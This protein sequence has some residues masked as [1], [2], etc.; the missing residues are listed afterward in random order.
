[1]YRRKLAACGTTGLAVIFMN[2]HFFLPGSC[3]AWQ[4]LCWEIC[5]RGEPPLHHQ[6]S[7]ER[8]KDLVGEAEYW[9][10]VAL[11]NAT[12]ALVPA[13]IWPAV[14]RQELQI[15]RFLKLVM[16]VYL[17]HLSVLKLL[18]GIL[19]IHNIQISVCNPESNSF[20]GRESLGNMACTA[21]SMQTCLI[22]YGTSVENVVV[23]CFLE[24]W[25]AGAVSTELV[26]LQ[27]TEHWCLWTP[28]CC[29]SCGNYMP[30]II[31]FTL[32]SH[33]R[34]RSHQFQFTCARQQSGHFSLFL[35]RHWCG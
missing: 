2:V 26:H 9:E 20:L 14:V 1:M 17:L 19:C 6:I 25:L 13:G 12:V 24:C 22:P 23:L 28:P 33:C 16:K 29:T 30:E 7:L 5:D 8:E 3:H 35:P 10:A 4:P 32:G 18:P 21:K 11:L 15:K 34:A 31:E 27:L